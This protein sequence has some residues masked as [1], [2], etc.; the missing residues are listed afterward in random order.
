[1]IYGH[2]FHNIIENIFGD[3]R[4]LYSSEQLQVNCPRCQESEGLYQTDGKF[5]LEINTKKRIY[6]CWKCDDPIFSGSLG[7]LIY[8]YGRKIDYEM[9]KS[10]VGTFDDSYSD[11][12][13]DD[14]NEPLKLPFEMISFSSMN[15]ED[16]D[17]FEAYN[18]LV[19]ERK[20]NRELI[21]RYRLGFC[22]NGKYA[23]RIIIPSF[24]CNGEV[25]YFVARSYDKTLGIKRPYDNPK[26][27]KDLIIFNDGM[28]NWDSTIFLVEGV[29]EMLS[30]PNAIPLLGKTISQALFIKLSKIKPYVIVLLDSD[31]NKDAINL[32]YLLKSIYYDCEERIK[33]IIPPKGK[34]NEQGKLMKDIDEIR[35]NNGND[36]VVKILKTARDLITDD[37]FITK[38][39]K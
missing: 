29:F 24:D 30:I 12:N 17:H 6:R 10:Y 18:Y 22:L 35:K 25:N 4:G 21:L 23:R 7:K 14:V 32:I 27:N 13:D 37:Y 8:T 28:T 31:A 16:S 33:L 34:F 20:I 36:E 3:V 5:N 2:E 15:V 1:M 26:S 11:G 39:Q 19:N 38:L 9:Y